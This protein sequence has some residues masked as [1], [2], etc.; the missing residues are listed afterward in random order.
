MMNTILLMA[1]FLAG[2]W[3]LYDCLQRI[4]NKKLESLR[5]MDDND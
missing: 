5:F 2:V 3:F 1:L 4:G